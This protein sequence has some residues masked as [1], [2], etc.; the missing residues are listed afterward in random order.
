MGGELCLY[1][2]VRQTSGFVSVA[3]EKRIFED[4]NVHFNNTVFFWFMKFGPS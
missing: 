4:E 2:A 1:H 3:V